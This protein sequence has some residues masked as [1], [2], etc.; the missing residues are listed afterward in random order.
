M[1]KQTASSADKII[2]KAF[3]QIICFK[4][5]YEQWAAPFV[6]QQTHT[7]LSGKRQRKFES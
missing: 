5:L 6:E 7:P 3:P 4:T 2:S 1:L